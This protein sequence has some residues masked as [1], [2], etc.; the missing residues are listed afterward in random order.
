L[1]T[2]AINAT[3][4][5]VTSSVKPA[6]AHEEAMRRVDDSRIAR[7]LIHAL[8]RCKQRRARLT[9]LRATL[10]KLMLRERRPVTA[11]E[12][13]RLLG[14]VQHRA[15]S[16]MTVYRAL[17]FLVGQGLVAHLARRNAYVACEHVERQ[18]AHLVF[19]C[20]K[21]GAAKECAD[22]TTE[23]R[24]ARA[25]SQIGFAPEPITIEIDGLCKNCLD[26][27]ARPNMRPQPR[28]PQPV[29]VRSA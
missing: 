24:F 9:A 21:C 12:L 4:R 16:P 26:V 2:S 22:R 7:S 13:V 8:E 29:K 27:T 20:G 28:R 3:S 15:V 6:A 17:D 14:R 5:D 10:L 25:A 23:R 11:Y 1:D 19:V 18:H